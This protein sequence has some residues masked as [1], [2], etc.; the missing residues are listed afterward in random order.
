MKGDELQHIEITE[1]S[2]GVHVTR[3]DF[4]KVVGG[5]ILICFSA[6]ALPAQERAPQRSPGDQSLPDDFNAFLR[7]GADGRVTCFTGK[8]EMGQGAV[9][10]LAQMLADELDISVERVDMVM[11][12]TDLCPWDMGTFG[13]RS[14]RFF[15]PPLREAAAEARSLLLTMAA[16]RLGVPESRLTVAD[17]VIRDREDDRRQITY[18]QLTKGK[19][20][21]RRVPAKPALKRIT[22]FKVM[23]KSYRR[24]DGLQK[25]TG[26]ALYAGDI[27][28]PGM[29]YAKVLRPPVHGAKLK[30][31]DASALPKDP[32][33]LYINEPDLVA[34]CHPYPDV[35]EKAL[36][37]LKAEYARPENMVD[38][39]TI[40]D[41]LLKSAPATGTI[42]TEAG[43]LQEG[44]RLASRTFAA[45]YFD[46][47]FA[48]ASMET[49]AAVAKI[50]DGK[51]TVWASTQMPFPAKESIARA[52]GM[53]SRQ[54]RVIAPFVGGGFGGKSFHLQAIEAARLA[55]LTGKPVQV[56]WSRQEAFFLDTFR[57]A[58]IVKISSGMDG[59]GKIVF[60]RYD[61]YYAGQRGIEQIYNVPHHR[62]TAIVNRMWGHE[63]HP[64]GTGAWRAPGNNTNCFAKESQIDIMAAANGMDPLSFRL[65]NL[66]DP[67]M[68]NT[69]KAVAAKFGWRDGAAPSGRG[70]G[71]ACGVD[72][73]S[74]VAAMAEVDVD[75]NSGKVMVKRLVCAQDMG[76]VINPEGAKQQMEGCL[77]MGLGYALTEE[78]RFRG[79]QIFTTNFDTYEI[80]RFSALPMIETVLVDN[81]GL[82]PQG[83]GEP[84]ITL[85]GAVIA[86]AVFDATGARL[87][88]MP[89]TP[90]RVKDALKEAAG[91][92]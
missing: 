10:S 60:W 6:D 67:R 66:T 9:T 1:V 40:H 73:G 64:F 18:A 29:L 11:G 20:I 2:A 21:E 48:H 14:T 52:L 31:V 49:H 23:G 57:P 28:L 56:M 33:L 63:A 61:V 54:V 62:E 79:G 55:K 88:R 68:I 72:A 7:I 80:P 51:A 84:A 77:T 36:A 59:A 46:D 44:E 71:I 16:R 45:T 65:H 19:R 34:V 12:D 38:V 37:R 30:R 4:L 27:R 39:S 13:S 69:L 15:G 74:Y 78:V 22:D 8:I 26:R 5:G 76:V 92:K 87:Y 25:V 70:V 85:V 58:A 89:M 75:K 91:G 53:P 24:K 41:H 43:D 17:G 35:A 90:N 81:P 3:R 42:I 32:A 86:N 47:Y 82:P 50:E 83:G